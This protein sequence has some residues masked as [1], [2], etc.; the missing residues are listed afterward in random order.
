[1]KLEEAKDV[2][3]KNNCSLFVMARED[4]D[5]YILYKELNI[6]NKLECKWKTEEINNLIEILEKN[7]SINIF[8][9]LYD[10]LASF[11]DKKS[12]LL[13]MKLISKVKFEDD[14]TALVL[15]EI[16]MGRKDIS[17]RG[18]MIFWSYE[19]GLIDETNMLIKKV[20]C[21]IDIKSNKD[22]DIKRVERNQKKI[23]EII[24]CLGLNRENFV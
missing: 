1:M 23:D 22:E 21:L 6:S 9:R 11:R 14:I 10:L 2:Y 20:L 18:G 5:N 17:I 15:A 12:L 8:D 16:I 4:Q 24:R 19:L 3:K 7:G 13:I